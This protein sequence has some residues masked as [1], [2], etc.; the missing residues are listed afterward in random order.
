MRR[1]GREIRGIKG[2]CHGGAQRWL[3]YFPGVTSFPLV[4]KAAQS[5]MDPQLCFPSL[6][7]NLRKDRRKLSDRKGV[8]STSLQ[9]FGIKFDPKI[10]EFHDFALKCCCCIQQFRIFI[11]PDRASPSTNFGSEF[12]G[13]ALERL[14][15]SSW[16]HSSNNR[17]VLLEE[18][19]KRKSLWSLDPDV[20]V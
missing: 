9:A 12:T 3:R 20:E 14:E 18:K 2:S 13:Y 1:K 8:S 7:F 5:G 4:L 6:D 10:A 15:S 16:H 11:G 19:S 17:L